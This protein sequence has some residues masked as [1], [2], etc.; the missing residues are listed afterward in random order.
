M[1]EPPPWRHWVTI[2]CQGFKTSAFYKMSAWYCER[3]GARVG[4]VW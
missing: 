3:C 4:V 1:S 2:Y